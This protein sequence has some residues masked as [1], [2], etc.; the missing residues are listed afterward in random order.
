MR[1]W[2]GWADEGRHPT[3]PSGALRLIEAEL[4]PGHPTPDAALADVVAAAPAIID[5]GSPGVSRSI[6]KTKNAM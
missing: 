5:A 1:R 6:A 2:N 3:L 4:G